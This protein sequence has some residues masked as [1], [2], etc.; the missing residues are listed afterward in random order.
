MLVLDFD[1]V[2]WNMRPASDAA[3]R[4]ML[5]TLFFELSVGH[6]MPDPECV[7]APS[8]G[9]VASPIESSLESSDDVDVDTLPRAPA[10]G[11]DVLASRRRLEK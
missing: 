10:S 9:G 11:R 7:I 3:F 4:P 8:S 6:A 2:R 1:R 5:P